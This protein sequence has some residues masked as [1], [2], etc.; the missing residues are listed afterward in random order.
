VSSP[1]PAEGT[2]DR[3][4]DEARRLRHAEGALASHLEA[5]GYAEVV[6]PLLEREGV[7]SDSDAVRLVDRAGQVLG[8][9]PDFTSSI[10][11]LVAGRLAHQG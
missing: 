6:V 10:A 8:L 5:H 7:W 11:R 2:I 3:L 9:R 4:P 1:W